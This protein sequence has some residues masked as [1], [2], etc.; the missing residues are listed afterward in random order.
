MV[1]FFLNDEGIINLKLQ[2]MAFSCSPDPST[3]LLIK[4][5]T[6]YFCFTNDT[7]HGK[8]ILF[9]QKEYQS[10]AS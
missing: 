6:D 7:S 9:R 1:V 8:E 5:S 10:I 2:P 4:K 3:L